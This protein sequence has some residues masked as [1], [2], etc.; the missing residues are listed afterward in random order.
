M[1]NSMK[2]PGGLPAIRRCKGQWDCRST[3]FGAIL[4]RMERDCQ[5]AA[6]RSADTV[7]SIVSAPAMQP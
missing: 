6:L 7:R 5:R 3:T 1:G 2:A 4:H